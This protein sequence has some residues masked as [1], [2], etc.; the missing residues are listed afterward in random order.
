MR[1]RLPPCVPNDCAIGGI[2]WDDSSSVVELEFMWQE[3]YAAKRMIDEEWHRDAVRR[4]A[5]VTGEV[6]RDLLLNHIA[7]ELEVNR[8]ADRIEEEKFL[9]RLAAAAA[10]L[11]E[12]WRARAQ[13]QLDRVTKDI[14][15]DIVRRERLRFLGK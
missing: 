8:N 12:A 4:L 13:A 9:D 6:E 14:N 2:E 10:R 15:A 3:W 1:R 5:G 7:A 11:R